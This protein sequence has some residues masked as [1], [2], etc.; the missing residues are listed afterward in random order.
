M[1][2]SGA[3]INR[4]EDTLTRLATAYGA[5]ADVYVIIYSIVVTLYF[6]GGRYVTQT[7]RTADRD[8]IN[9]ARLDRLNSFSRRCCRSPYTLEQF[10]REL[11]AIREDRAHP[12]I[13]YAGYM[14]GAFSFSVFFG[15]SFA[16]GL[17][18]ALFSL[19]IVLLQN[20]LGRYSANRILYTLV[21]STVTGLGIGLCCQILPFLNQPMVM[22]GDIMLL[23]P[24]ITMI[25]A[26]R[27]MMVG[28]TISG[29]IRFF[30]SFSWALAL[31]AGFMLGMRMV[32]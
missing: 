32:L 14:I 9:F 22:I 20:T 26:V 10:D 23:N 7:R 13:L 17:A 12:W 1:L 6:P 3:E 16:D 5:R 18:A 29:Q 27:E 11:E 24:G 28:N 25:N 15:G 21:V 4:V 31:A 8:D 2:F 30:E 19:L